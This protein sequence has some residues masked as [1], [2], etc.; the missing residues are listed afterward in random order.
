[1]AL[2]SH[3]NRPLSLLFVIAGMAA[4]IGCQPNCRDLSFPSPADSPYVLSY[5]VGESY[6]VSQTCCNP[7][8]GHR[9]R[10][11]VDF[12]MALGAAITASR[13]G[14]VVAVVEGFVDGDLGRGH[15]N[16]VLIRHSDGS[17]AWY[18]HLQQN[19]VVVE[20]GETVETGQPI[21]RCGNTGNTGNLPHLHFEV[22]RRRAF[23]YSDAIPI[24]FRNAA[25]P[26]HD[27]GSMAG[28]AFYEALGQEP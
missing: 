22:F 24:S 9:N 2:A 25:G 11:A 28:G 17:V 18:A 6:L 3:L 7:R 14:E 13:G 21:A 26:L 20:V 15:N 23:D 19:S 10:I 5:P 16:R 8:G 27:N 12:K 4:I 1:M